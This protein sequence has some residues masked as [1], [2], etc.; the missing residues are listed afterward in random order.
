MSTPVEVPPPF[1]VLD[2]MLGSMVTQTIYVAA[3][4]GIA[5]LLYTDG[6][7][8][9]GEIA[10]KVDA[11]PESLS[12]LLRFLASYGIFAEQ[13]GRYAL[14]PRAD[15]LRSDAPMSMRGMA[16][17]MGHPTHWAD[18]TGFLETIRTGE[19]AV[20][21]RHGG[22]NMFEL[23]MTDQDYG[24]IFF[25]GMTNLSDTETVP[26]VSGYDWSQFGTIVDVG[27]GRGGLLA[28]ILQAAPD[29]RGICF[30]ERAPGNGAGEV[31]EAAGVADRVRIE[32]GSFF[33]PAPAGGDAYLLKH[34]V[35]DWPHEQ[36][37]QI[38]R[39]I[40]AVAGPDT[41]LLIMEF[42]LPEDSSPHI[43]KLIDLWL[44]LLLGGVERTAS[45]Y[46]ELLAEAGWQLERVVPTMAT[47]AIVEARPV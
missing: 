46:A 39:N 7:L 35:H 19:P 31:L 28:A 36:T 32:T 30:D 14:T 21:K 5:D 33:G 13:D 1:A 24:Q 37:V 12:R 18:W 9:A 27:A 26:L 40:R 20:P 42:V 38:L 10:R 44:L 29:S 23:V 4:L 3:E 17:L 45:Q 2:L 47:I 15:A 11:D 41:R 43:G 8:P 34:I 25:G 22:M 16:R 6:P